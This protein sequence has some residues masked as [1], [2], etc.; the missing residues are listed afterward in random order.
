M[1]NHIP[2]QLRSSSS[3]LLALYRCP[4]KPTV[5]SPASYVCVSPASKGD[6]RCRWKCSTRPFACGWYAVVRCSLGPRSLLARTLRVSPKVFVRRVMTVSY[7]FSFGGARSRSRRRTAL[8]W[9]RAR[10]TWFGLMLCHIL[11]T[12]PLLAGTT[13]EVGRSRKW[14]A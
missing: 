6:F 11:Q 9:S 14:V 1:E 8:S 7:L 13:P 2:V 10:H 3:P 4:I 12:E 5:V